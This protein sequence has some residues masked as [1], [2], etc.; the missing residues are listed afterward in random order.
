MNRDTGFDTRLRPGLLPE[1]HLSKL[2]VFDCLTAQVMTDAI[3]TEGLTK[4]FGEVVGVAELDLS[5]SFGTVYGF[6]GPNG[7]G[8]TTTLQLLAGLLDADAGSARIDGTSTTR[9]R[10]LTDVLGY[11]PAEAPLYDELT[12]REQLRYAAQFRHLDDGRVDEA[13]ERYGL[14]DAADRRVEGYSTGMRRRL[15]LAQATLHDPAVLLLD[16]PLN[17]L[18]PQATRTVTDLVATVSDD[19]TA[20][21]VSSHDLATVEV[22]CDRV[23]IIADGRLV[24]EDEPDEL[25]DGVDDRADL[26]AA[27]I[28]LTDE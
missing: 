19:G 22:I 13:L 18:D 12:G 8:K 6:V 5:V 11:L 15:G 21:L 3:E 23:G 20:V 24:A 14:V 28:E 4:R 2:F 10:E 7:A 16:E 17:G 26:E 27:V 1:T 9:R 25:V